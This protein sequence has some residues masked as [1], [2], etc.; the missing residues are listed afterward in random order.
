[1]QTQAVM[2]DWNYDANCMLSSLLVWGIE[3][4]KCLVFVVQSVCRVMTVV[5]GLL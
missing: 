5:S 4:Y 3:M 1:M 2:N